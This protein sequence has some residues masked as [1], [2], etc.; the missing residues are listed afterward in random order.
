MNRRRVSVLAGGVVAVVMGTAIANANAAAAQTVNLTF[1]VAEYDNQMQP[2]MQHLIQAF[3]RRNP[4][5]H[6]QLL[7]SNWD[8]YHD[9]LVTWIAG[10]HAP[11]IANV[12][13]LWIGEFNDMQV[14]QPLNGYTSPSF[15]K[16][17][18]QGPL[19][20]FKDKNGKLLGLPF[21]LDPRELYYRKD[22]FQKHHLSPPKTWADLYKDAQIL[23]HPPQVYGF[24]VGGKYPNV[25]TGFE[26]F[27]FNS[28]PQVLPVHFGKNGKFLFNSP[29]GVHALTFLNNLVRNGLTNP[30]PDDVE[31]ENGVQPIFE[32]GHLAMMITGPW[33]AGMLDKEKKVQYGIAP[34]PTEKPG[35]KSRAVMEPDAIVVMSQDPSKRVAIEKFL[36]F[37]YQPQN[38][39]TFALHHGN[40][41]ELVSVAENPKWLNMPH[42]RFFASLLPNAINKYADVGK[43][44]DQ[45]DRIV[46]TEIQKVYLQQV[47]PAQALRTAAQQVEQLYNGK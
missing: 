31:W 46:T 30:N 16:Q 42:N 41:P 8:N 39:L 11:D 3:E 27:Y 37:L 36:Q 40:I 28:S 45:M 32:S 24:G 15:L 43:Y 21:F 29:N 35:M 7:M 18:F 19:N 26:Y 14:L 13:G 33:F 34:V 23:S 17:F 6:V 20:S 4:N 44:G 47:T 1:S 12:S 5:I 10:N 22:L 9:R 2:D 25:M 38:R